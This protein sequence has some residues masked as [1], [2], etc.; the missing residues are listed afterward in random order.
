M[1]V[2]TDFTVRQG[3]ILH[4]ANYIWV[5]PTVRKLHDEKSFNDPVFEMVDKHTREARYVKH[6][7]V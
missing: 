3:L 5:A 7:I 1:H 4:V 2:G 6:S